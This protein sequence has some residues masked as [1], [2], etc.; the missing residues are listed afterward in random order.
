MKVKEPK[1]RCGTGNAII[2]LAVELDLP[3][4]DG[5][6]DWSYEVAKPN[7]IEKYI[8]HYDKLIDEDKKFV[9]M[10]IMIQATTDQNNE[11]D[12]KKYWTEL[13]TRLL[14]DKV[15]HEYTLYYWSCF[16][17][18]DLND[19]WEITPFVRSLW[20]EIRNDR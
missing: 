10:E 1:F 4:N 3:Y 8:R 6:Q 7:E 5:M 19:C 15:I 17:N 20:Q 16:D 2:E 11:Y 18:E 14:S 13:K 12:L 9:L